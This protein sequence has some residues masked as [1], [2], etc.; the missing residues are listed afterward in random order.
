MT[1]IRDSLA[2]VQAPNLLP[3]PHCGD[4]PQHTSTNAWCAY[5]EGYKSHELWNTR[6]GA[7]DAEDGSIR[8]IAKRNLRRMIEIGST[9]TKTMLLC[10]EELS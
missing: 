2:Q 4:M 6:H 3:C 5:C 1:A 10:L 9:D 8:F 7:G